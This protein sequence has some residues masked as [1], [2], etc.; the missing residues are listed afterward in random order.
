MKMNK[1]LIAGVML[2]VMRAA[3]FTGCGGEKKEEEAPAAGGKGAEIFG[4]AR[5]AEGR[6]DHGLARFAQKDRRERE[7]GGGG[8]CLRSLHSGAGAQ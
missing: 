1:K 4:A 3:V 7:K 6:G 8:L 5:R 2:A